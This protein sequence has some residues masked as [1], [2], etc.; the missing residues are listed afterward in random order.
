MTL[1]VVNATQNVKVIPPT[2]TQAYQEL[3]VFNVE[4]LINTNENYQLIG[5][6]LNKIC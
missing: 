6:Y 1:D 5:L 4:N 2:Y 3:Q